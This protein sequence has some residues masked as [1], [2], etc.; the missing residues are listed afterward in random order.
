MSSQQGKTGVDTSQART[1]AIDPKTGQPMR[2][3]LTGKCS[4]PNC[5]MEDSYETET[6]ATLK[7]T[8]YKFHPDC[9]TQWS[10]ESR[11]SGKFSMQDRIA[12]LDE[13]TGKNK[14]TAGAE[15]KK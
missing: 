5:P 4:Y 15:V 1:R 13:Q 7:N 14:K 6:F 12:L 3:K 8:D 2:E 11:T 9:M 10:N